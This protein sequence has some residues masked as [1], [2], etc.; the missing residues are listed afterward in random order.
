MSDFAEAL[1][2]VPSG[3]FV[4]TAAE[5][6]QETGMLASWVQ[7]CSFDPP[8]VSVAVKPD[9]FI[10]AWLRDGAAFT[11]NLIPDGDRRL[12]AHFGRGF[13]AGEPAF[14]GL[15]VERPAGEAPVLA[16]ALGHLLC[17]VVARCKAG[18]HDLIVGTVTGGR[19]HRPDGKPAIHV[20]KSGLRY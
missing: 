13:G 6:Q 5:G 18:D 19:L 7:Q 14:T 4:L 11:L 16:D 2:R 8:G 9:R 3:L 1:G 15:N 17:R 12:M 10:N 20:R